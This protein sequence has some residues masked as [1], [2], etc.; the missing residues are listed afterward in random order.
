MK[1]KVKKEKKKEKKKRKWKKGSATSIT[2]I[3]C[4]GLMCGSVYKFSESLREKHMLCFVRYY[5]P[6]S[7]AFLF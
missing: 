7:S 1:F 4:F 3:Y 6:F 2:T 5:I